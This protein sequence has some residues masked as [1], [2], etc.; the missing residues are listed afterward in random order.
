MFSI[1]KDLRSIGKEF[2]EILQN[3][4]MIAINQDS[5]GI[6]GK[7]IAKV[8]S[9]EIWSKS[10]SNDYTAFVFLNKEP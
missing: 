2:V 8:N 3:K 10:L 9:I 7:R 6:M 5:L 4:N 1:L